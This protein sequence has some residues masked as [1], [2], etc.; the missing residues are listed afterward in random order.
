MVLYQILCIIKITTETWLKASIWK[1]YESLNLFLP[2]GVKTHSSRPQSASWA[3]LRALSI[4][5]ICQQA[6][7]AS[8]NTFIKHYMLDLSRS[9]ASSHARAV[10]DAHSH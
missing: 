9:V 1:A 10:L 2:G 3:N 5:D 8:H 6:S 4:L 7:W